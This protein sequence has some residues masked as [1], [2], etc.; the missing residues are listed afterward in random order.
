MNNMLFA[1]IFVQSFHVCLY[2]Q[3]GG[4]AYILCITMCTPRFIIGDYK[5]YMK[6]GSDGT[7]EFQVRSVYN[8][9]VVSNK[10]RQ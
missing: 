5:R 2:T 9:H 3:Y 8:P 4:Y 7:V 6:S 10:R 1:L